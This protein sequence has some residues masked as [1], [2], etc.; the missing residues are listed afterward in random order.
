VKK[1]IRDVNVAGKKVLVRVDYNVP[2]DKDG[3]ITDITRITATLPTIKYL[4]EQGAAVILASH[5]GRPKGKP[6]PEFSLAPVAQRLAEVLGQKVLFAPD[7]VGPEAE[8]MAKNLQPGEILLLENLRFHPEEEKNDREFARQL[9]GLGDLLVNDAF[10]V[11]HRAHASVH[12]I[13]EFLPAVAGFLME[14][15]ITFLG[16]AVTNPKRPFVAIIGGAKVSD[17]IGVLENLLT[18]VDTLIIGGG[19]ANTFIAAQG[20]ETGKSL[21]EPD[22][23]EL[24]KHLMAVARERG[25]NLLLPVDVVAAEKFAPDAAHKVVSVDQIPADWQALDIGPATREAFATAIAQAATIVW[26]GPMGVFE[27]DAFAGGTVAVAQ[28]VAASPA[29]SIVGGGDS[30]AALEKANVADRISHVSTGGG[31]SLEFLEGKTLPGIAVLAERRR[32]LIVGNWK[33][34]KTVTEA[35]ELVRDLLPQVKEAAAEVVVCPPF[36]ALQA[37]SQVLAGSEVRLGAQDVHWERA[38]AYT[39]EISAPMLIDA[40]C[41]YVIIGHSERRQLLGETDV[42]VNK[43]VAAAL[44]EGL[45]PIICVGETL[46]QRQA[47]VTNELIVRQVRAALNDLTV[48]QAAK[49]VIAYEP[50]WAI[51]TGKTALPDDANAVCALIRREIGELY[52]AKVAEQVRILYGGSVKPDNIA[53]FMAMSDIDGALVGG[54]SLNAADFSK[55]VRY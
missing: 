37:V 3:N 33:M 16:Q 48:D 45:T 51:G 21:V 46:E 18:K 22:K 8:A 9:A 35:V 29:I 36:T 15:E 54:A 27:M 31:A 30:I 32:P 23:I 13:A 5:L 12:G 4:L 10:G 49:V 50:L 24:A 47:G 20:Y 26:N 2:M 44:A 40:G 42:M 38:G 11:S 17:K 52:G 43:K 6:V 28:A 41:T 39:G 7:C 1:T 25:V 19:M 34:H 14:K 53:G 55:I